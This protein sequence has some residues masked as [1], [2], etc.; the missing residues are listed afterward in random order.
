MFGPYLSQW[1]RDRTIP[2]EAK[3]KA[4]GL[5]VVSFALSIALVHATWFTT[6]KTEMSTAG[7]VL[8]L[9]KQAGYVPGAGPEL[10]SFCNTG[11]WAATNWFA[12]SEIA[13]IE[14]VKLYPES[15][16]GWSISGGELVNGS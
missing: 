3:R 13:G 12:L 14:G 7:R 8:E 10:V 4:Y 2:R 11:Q 9:A 16:V 15:V 6:S 5:V 1:Q